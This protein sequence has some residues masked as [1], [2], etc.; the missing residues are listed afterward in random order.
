MQSIR[1]P[2]S[3]GDHAFS[4]SKIHVMNWTAEQ[5]VPHG[6]THNVQLG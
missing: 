6:A 3:K 1:H 5:Q 4:D 2:A